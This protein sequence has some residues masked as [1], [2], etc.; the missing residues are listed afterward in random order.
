[1]EFEEELEVV[2]IDEA[3]PGN[4]ITEMSARLNQTHFPKDTKV[5][6][7]NQSSDF[8]KGMIAA[9]KFSMSLIGQ[10]SEE[11]M[12]GHLNTLCFNAILYAKEKESIIIMP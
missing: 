5:F 8:Y 3:P 10:Y 6:A 7:G 1:M 9:A 12:L 11:D 4:Y 2:M